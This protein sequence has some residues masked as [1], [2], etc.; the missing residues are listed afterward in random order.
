MLVPQK[1]SRLGMEFSSNLGQLL[2][3][4]SAEL[5]A[6]YSVSADTNFYRIGRI[7]LESVHTSIVVI[8]LL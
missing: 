1:M 8:L 4:Y 7:L 6:E 2:G 3:H 5:S